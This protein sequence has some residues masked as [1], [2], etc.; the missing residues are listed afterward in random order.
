M[1]YMAL[2]DILIR[3][4]YCNTGGTCTCAGVTAYLIF[5]TVYYCSKPGSDMKLFGEQSRVYL[6]ACVVVLG[7]TMA[8]K[9]E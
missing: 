7:V 1:R 5:L 9:K 4:M 6:M 2:Y 3:D 8:K